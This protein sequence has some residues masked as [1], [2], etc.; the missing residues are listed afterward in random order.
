MRQFIGKVLREITSEETW[1]IVRVM[2]Y[3]HAPGEG[4]RVITKEYYIPFIIVMIIAILGFIILYALLSG[5]RIAYGL[6]F[7]AF[8]IY[9]II[10]NGRKLK[11]AK[12]NVGKWITFKRIVLLIISIVL[13]LGG[14]AIIINIIQNYLK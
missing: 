6:C 4:I 9:G 10:A 11:S 3:D 1:K 7:T 8:G 2:M 5:V 12:E 13:L 14:L